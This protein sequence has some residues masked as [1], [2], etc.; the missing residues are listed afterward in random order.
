VAELLRHL[1]ESAEREQERRRRLAQAVAAILDAPAEGPEGLAPLLR[2][3]AGGAPQ[4]DAA[5]VVAP[6]GDEFVVVAALG[7]DAQQTRAPQREL[8]ILTEVL[9]TRRVIVV[10]GDEPRPPL[11]EGTRAAAAIPALSAGSALAV[12]VIGSR[13]ALEL[14]EDAVLL[15]RVV[16]ERAAR[17]LERR[18]LVTSLSAAE[19][20][21][22]KT[23]AFRDQ[24]LAIVG[25]D[26]RNPL[27]AVAMSA[28]LLSKRGGLVGWQAKTVSRVRSSAARMERII[29]DLLSYTRT[30]LGA[31]IPIDPRDADLGE[32]A[33]KVVDE[34]VAFHPNSPIHVEAEGDLTG[35]WD[36]SRLEQVLSNVLSNAVDHGEPDT[37][38]DVVLRGAG[39]AVGVEVVNRG[40]MPPGMLEHAFEAFQRPPEKEARRGAGLGLGLFIAREI[41][42]GHGGTIEVRSRNGETRLHVELPRRPRNF[43]LEAR[44]R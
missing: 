12:V 34:L 32:L 13:S 17:A 24:I 36:P 2:A 43:A 25:H 9:R 15:A 4:V 30:R 28:A 41:V 18:T 7:V 16:A 44:A 22:R 21:A 14:G 6:D 26:L 35:V 3:L 37:R 19:T 33:R 20:V 29:A 38:I 27:G 10:S 5:L 39:L 11:P 8:A 42:R 23:T 31:G 1:S 40:E